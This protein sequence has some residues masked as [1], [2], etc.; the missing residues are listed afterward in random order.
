MSLPTLLLGTMSMSKTAAHIPS[1]K[2]SSWFWKDQRKL[3]SQRIVFVCFDILE[4][5]ER[6][7]A[8]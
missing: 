2:V 8:R 3:Y 4:V 7:D 6:A 1:G 5:T